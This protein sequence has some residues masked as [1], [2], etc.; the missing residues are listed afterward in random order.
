MIA[1]VATGALVWALGWGEGPTPVALVGEIPR[2][3][4]QLTLPHFSVEKA[5]AVFASSLAIA[6]LGMVEAISIGKALSR[7]ARIKFY[8]DQELLAKGAGN[9]V[10]AFFGCM[11]SSASWTRS[12]INM[13]MGAKTRWAGVIAGI[14]VLA[15]MLVFAP[16][17]RYLPK[18]C[19]GAL[20]AWIAL[21][22]VDLTAARTVWQW[23]RADAAVLVITCVS[24]LLLDIQYAIY[25]GVFVSLLMLVRRAGTLHLVEMVSAASKGFREIEIDPK[26]GSYPV[27]LLQLEGDL[28]FGVVEEL[29]EKLEQVAQNGARAIIIR[30]KRTHAIDASAA[31]SLAAFAEHF[32][33]RGGRMV[34]C[35]LKPEL[36]EQIARSYLGEALGPENVL[37]TEAQVFGSIRN[38]IDAARRDI[39]AQGLRSLDKPMIRPA[40]ADLP[41]APS[42]SI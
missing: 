41:D 5:E 17:A 10:G 32:K 21:H 42:Y 7:K 1:V 36:Y 40:P 31:A 27:V 26:T 18:A 15:I 39:S 34:L 29:E 23:S 20:I 19:L 14:A 11:P 28:F 13:Q 3:L 37:R 22:M 38:A 16:W 25:L 24:T 2:T 8:A 33:T 4:P 9:V 35:G 6:L 12:A 30:L